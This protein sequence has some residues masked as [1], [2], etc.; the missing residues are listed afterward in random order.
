LT[1]FEASLYLGNFEGD[2]E[3][4]LENMKVEVTKVVYK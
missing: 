3:L 4:L 1:G 2:N